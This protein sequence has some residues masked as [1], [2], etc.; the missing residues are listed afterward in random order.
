MAIVFLDGNGMLPAEFIQHGQTVNSYWTNLKETVSWKG[1]EC[2]HSWARKWLT[3]FTIHNALFWHCSFRLS[4]VWNSETVFIQ[5]AIPQRWHILS[6][7]MMTP[8]TWLSFFK[9]NIYV[10]MY[11]QDR[12]L[13]FDVDY[14]EKYHSSFS[15][16]CKVFYFFIMNRWINK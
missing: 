11:R 10:L 6:R 8:V 2:L 14:M 13:N 16:I 1:P 7:C 12:C 9:L 4:A 15:N 5:E 3:C